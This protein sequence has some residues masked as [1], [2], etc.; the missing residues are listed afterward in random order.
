[1][2]KMELEQKTLFP[3]GWK[4]R[5]DVNGEKVKMGYLRLSMALGEALQTSRSSHG[6]A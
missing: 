4:I 6:D 1:M 2:K 3:F 5:G